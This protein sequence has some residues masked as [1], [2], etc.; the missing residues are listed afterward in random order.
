MPFNVKYCAKCEYPK[1]ERLW[2]ALGEEVCPD[3]PEEPVEIEWETEYGL[4][5]VDDDDDDQ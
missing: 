4:E 1:G 2:D 5:P 3:H